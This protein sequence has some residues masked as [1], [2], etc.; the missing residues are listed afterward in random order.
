MKKKKTHI[1]K[2]I[3]IAILLA[4]LIMLILAVALYDFIPN[5]VNIV[6]PIEYTADSAT[7]SVKQEIDTTNNGD[8]TADQQQTQQEIVTSLKSYSIEATDLTVYGQKNLYNSG[9]SNPFDYAPD[10]TTT[11]PTDGNTANNTVTEQQ[12]TTPSTNSATA[13][14][15]TS[16]TTTNSPTGT[17]FESS[18]SK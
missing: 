10:D 8:L 15:T 6:E 9:N 14:N 16:N 3:F 18:T 2:E 12:A 7:T 13:T 1:E 4:I 5:D 11:Q 17:F